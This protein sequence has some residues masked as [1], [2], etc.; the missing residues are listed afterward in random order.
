MYV[1]V[2]DCDLIRAD[3]EPTSNQ[4]YSLHLMSVPRQ[5]GWDLSFNLDCLKLDIIFVEHFKLG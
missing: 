5:T 4:G 3:G 1:V 2:Y